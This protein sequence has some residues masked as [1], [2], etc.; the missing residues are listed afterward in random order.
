MFDT[1]VH[2][3][4]DL[5]SFSLNVLGEIPFF[6]INEKDKI[7]SNPNDRSVVSESFRMLMSNVKYLLKSEKECNVMVVSSS[8]KGEG[9]TLVALNLSLAFASLNKKVLLLGCDLRNPQIHKHIDEDKNQKGLVNF[10]VD[11]KFNW[12]ESTLKKFDHHPTH[13][14]LLS[15]S[16]PPNPLNLI[17]NGNLDILIEQAK[18]YYDYIIIDSAP[19][20]LVADTKS[21]YLLSDAMVYMIRSGITEKEIIKH[22]ESLSQMSEL[23]LGVVLNG[24][25]QKNSYGYSYGY[26]YGYGYNYKYS[27]NYGYGYGYEEDKS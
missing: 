4:E 1:K 25:G 5:E 16:L 23:N 24:V 26:K 17:N 3:K 7:F 12:R 2:S 11:S 13:D 15:G 21:L 10:L 18:K 27:Y 8:I 6:D 9:K 22:I 19:T 14:I 20:L